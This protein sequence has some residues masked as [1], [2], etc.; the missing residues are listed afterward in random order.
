MY[1][2]LRAHSSD[3][4]ELW[5]PVESVSTLWELNSAEELDS[6]KYLLN[7]SNHLLSRFK[8]LLFGGPTLSFSLW[9]QANW[10]FAGGMDKHSRAAKR[11]LEE[12]VVAR[13]IDIQ[14]TNTAGQLLQLLIYEKNPT[15]PYITCTTQ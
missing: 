5:Q 12:Q 2:R 11:R 7:L 9:K 1:I 8:R 6:P 13:V 14:T 3:T 4:A 15:S 10:A